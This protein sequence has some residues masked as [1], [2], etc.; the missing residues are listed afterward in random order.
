MDRADP[1]L[2][3]DQRWP[4]CYQSWRNYSLANFPLLFQLVSAV[5]YAYHCVQAAASRVKSST[6]CLII[7]VSNYCLIWLILILMDRAD[8][9]LLCD[10]RWPSCYQSWRNYSLAN[11]PFLFQ[12]VI[13]VLYAYH[14]VQAA[15][16]HVKVSTLCLIVLVS[17][18]CLIWLILILMDK[19]D[20][21][22]LCDQSWPSCYQSWTN[23]SL[24]NFPCLFQLVSAALYA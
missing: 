5:L 16:S 18:Y 6:L 7:L 11:F 1:E 17:K 8:P 22:L 13:A 23:Y 10:Q 2:L 24:A 20:P 3:C 12:L 4:S 21:D 14:C 19:A 15:A 9:E